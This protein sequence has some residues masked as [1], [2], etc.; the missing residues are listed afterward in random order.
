MVVLKEKYNKESRLLEIANE[1][2]NQSHKRLKELKESASQNEDKLLTV[3]AEFKAEM[4][5]MKQNIRAADYEY[6]ILKKQY[7]KDMASK[8]RIPDAENKAL[9]LKK[10]NENLED[11]NYQLRLKIE[12]LE[13]ELEQ[14]RR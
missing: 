4:E 13:K 1:E 5:I 6:F 2:L 9:E 8:G 3:K 10:E 12:R 11:D 7:E 14:L